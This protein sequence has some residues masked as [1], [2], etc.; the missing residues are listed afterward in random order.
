MA[1][2]RGSEDR[3]DDRI[4][5]DGDP[6]SVRV[7]V[8]RAFDV[9]AADAVVRALSQLI[10]GL[11]P[12]GIDCRWLV[13]RPSPVRSY[14]RSRIAALQRQ[15]YLWQAIYLIWSAGHL[16][17]NRHAYDVVLTVDAPVGIAVIGTLAR[18]LSRG[19]IKHVAWVLDLYHLQDQ[20]LQITRRR[21]G[22]RSSLWR[23]ERWALRTADSTV[24]LGECMRVRLI[25]EAQVDSTVVPIW[26]DDVGAGWEKAHDVAPAAA[27][28]LLY[29]G[30]AE[31][32]HPL[33]ALVQAMAE[34]PSNADIRLTLRGSG[35][36]HRAAEAAVA[37]L[38][39]FDRVA[40]EGWAAEGDRGWLLAASDV[41]V[42]SLHERATGTCVPS[43]TYAAMAMGRPVLYLG[44]GLGQAA[45]DVT[46]CG[47]GRIA[48][49]DDVAAIVEACRWFLDH[50]EER[51]VMGRRG[52]KFFL[53]HRSASA[54]IPTWAELLSDLAGTVRAPG[55]RDTGVG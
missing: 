31:D 18:S 19:R 2:V 7:L 52:R 34:L 33:V 36:Q 23:M 3:G 47:A 9:P 28:R 48:A 29:S 50:H 1:G 16:L 42:V 53:A 6:T 43:K 14:A 13:V 54:V 11:R 26:H 27:L 5:H 24:V 49:T 32:R 41:H 55:R 35:Q 22:L 8:L 30:T 45:R 46:D 39:L 38:A 20:A 10:E 12:Y 4:G 44:S 17:R 25:E 21:G 37:E 15:R 40:V 51:E